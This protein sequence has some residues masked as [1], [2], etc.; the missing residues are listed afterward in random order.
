MAAMAGHDADRSFAGLFQPAFDAAISG[1]RSGA[2]S[3]H[4]H[5]SARRATREADA[6]APVTSRVYL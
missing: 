5:Q 4:G 2:T 1:R 3:R 6:F